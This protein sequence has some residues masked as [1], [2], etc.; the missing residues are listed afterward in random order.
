MYGMGDLSN[1]WVLAR[2]GLYVC[3]VVGYVLCPGVPNLVGPNLPGPNMPQ[4]QKVWGP[5]CR[6]ISEG[7]DLPGPNL[8]RTPG[9]QIHVSSTSNW[10]ILL[11]LWESWA[12]LQQQWMMAIMGFPFFSFNRKMKRK[13]CGYLRSLFRDKKW[14]N[15]TQ[16]L[17]KKYLWNLISY[18]ETSYDIPSLLNGVNMWSE[19]V[20]PCQRI[21]HGEQ[22]A[23]L[24][25][26]RSANKGL[27]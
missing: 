17:R 1:L 14:A 19:K 11:N 9:C 15:T 10:G 4:H 22:K 25:E 13:K 7:P 18:F 8:P 5:I 3:F 6:Q 12:P 26:T 23:P 21:Y 24:L 27:M 20:K 16:L 2:T